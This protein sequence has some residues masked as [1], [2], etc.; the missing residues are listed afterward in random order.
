MSTLFG[1]TTTTGTGSSSTSF[2]FPGSA[3]NQPYTNNESSSPG[4]LLNNNNFHQ[5]GENVINNVLGNNNNNLFESPTAGGTTMLSYKKKQQSTTTPIENPLLYRTVSSMENDRNNYQNDNNDITSSSSPST[6]TMTTMHTQNHSVLQP[7]GTSMMY[8]GVAVSSSMSSVLRQ[9]KGF[10]FEGSGTPKLI[11]STV[12]GNM[13]MPKA[14]NGT[15]PIVVGRPQE[16]NRVLPPRASYSLGTH[17]KTQHQQRS[18]HIVS[19]SSSSTPTTMSNGLRSNSNT[20]DSHNQSMMMSSLS[21][22]TGSI[23]N[24]VFSFSTTETTG[25]YTSSNKPNL[26]VSTQS[27]TRS[28][29]STSPHNMY[30][31]SQVSLVANTTTWDNSSTFNATSSSVGGNVGSTT[32][33][34]V[35]GAIISLSTSGSIS[36]YD[37]IIH[38]L[39]EYGQIISHRGRS[40]WIAVQYQSEIEAEKAA[41]HRRMKFYTGTD[42][43]YVTIQRLLSSDPEMTMVLQT[44][45]GSSSIVT[46]NTSNNFA[47]QTTNIWTSNQQKMENNNTSVALG[48]IDSNGGLLLTAGSENGM[49]TADECSVDTVVTSNRRSNESSSSLLLDVSDRNKGIRNQQHDDGLLVNVVP[50]RLV[51]NSNEFDP[52]NSIDKRPNGDSICVMFLKW[53]L[54]IEEDEY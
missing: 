44:Q 34:F 54:S 49:R 3:R 43:I 22:T 40:N 45:Q 31:P 9:R 21:N 16:Q 25:R 10:A 35:F 50:R 26:H 33:V 11:D 28:I 1:N 39:G 5:Q 15:G 20:L 4:Y 19:S 46:S 30:S 52:M 18:N 36:L 24:N 23:T 37:E 48:R 42:T 2:V 7:F 8:Q 12:T 13:T 6:P 47:Q 38:R 32:W 53:F 17:N 14:M 27:S 29:S 41:C 51:Q